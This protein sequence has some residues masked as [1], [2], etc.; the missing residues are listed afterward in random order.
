MPSEYIGCLLISISD[1][2]LSN[3]YNRY[4]QFGYDFSDYEGETCFGGGIDIR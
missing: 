3:E 1:V 4:G 2:V